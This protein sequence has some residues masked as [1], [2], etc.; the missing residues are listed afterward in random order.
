MDL[1][2]I[3]VASYVSTRN[4]EPKRVDTTEGIAY[5]NGFRFAFMHMVN[6][7]DSICMEED[8]GENGGEPVTIKDNAVKYLRDA[9]VEW[10][11]LTGHID[12]IKDMAILKT[13]E[14]KD[15][16]YFDEGE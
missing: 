7:I 9:V 15:K 6:Y 12:R 16:D 11:R 1:N 8:G 14:S 3:I 10:A 5:C 2:D 13:Y 4:R